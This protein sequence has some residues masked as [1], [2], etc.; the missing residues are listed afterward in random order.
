MEV[1]TRVFMDDPGGQRL[2]LAPI[3]LANK[4]DFESAF[5]NLAQPLSDYSFACNYIWGSS[6]KLYWLQTDRH[7]CVFANG[8]GDLTL[9]VP[10]IPYQGANDADMRDC[11]GR[12]FDIMDAYNAVHAQRSC[13]RIEYVSDELLERINTATVRGPLNLGATPMSGDYVYDMARMIDLAGGSLKSKR[14]ARSKFLREHPDARVVPYDNTWKQACLD[15]L[16]LWQH[17]GDET[18]AGEVNEDRIGSNELRHRDTLASRCALEN[19]QQLGLTGMVL[20]VGDK[21]IGFTFG[22]TISATQAS[23]LIEKTDYHYDGAA[24]YIFSEFCRLY[25]SHLPECNAGDDWGLP[26]LRFTKQSYR[27][28]RILNKSVLAR[29]SIPLVMGYQG[30]GGDDSAAASD[31][32]LE[33]ATDASLE[34]SMEEMPSAAMFRRH[35]ETQSLI[36][37]GPERVF[38]LNTSSGNS[39]DVLVEPATMSDVD[40][41]LRLEAACFEFTEERFCRRQVRSLMTNPRATVLVARFEGQVVGWLSTLIRQDRAGKVGR[42]YAI[43]VHPQMQ[44][45]HIGR[46]LL[47]HGLNRLIQLAPR[48]IVLEVREGNDAAISLY[49][50]LGFVDQ[51]FLPDYYGPGRHGY[52]MHHPLTGTAATVRETSSAQETRNP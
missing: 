30:S 9:L 18:H 29:A 3:E 43:G 5:S 23:I 17:H 6:L 49:R 25:W 36:S 12:C 40:A 15:V 47:E 20:L 16:D 22:E 46:L 11:L 19:Y 31:H 35:D 7:L 28:V 37:T 21:V 14:H 13:S 1:A 38:D 50:K 32:P 27:P 26:K 39:P 2:G 24:Q 42:I 4:F 8:T 45:R 33:D 10:P 44:G 52:R 51:Q 41:I 48:R 34:S